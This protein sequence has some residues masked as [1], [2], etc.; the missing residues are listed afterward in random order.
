[1]SVY[2]DRVVK[3]SDLVA[4]DG[5]IEGQTFIGCHIKGPAVI[6]AIES[7]MS[8]C[9]LGGPDGNSVF[10]EVDPGQRPQI[11]G[12][13]VCKRCNFE[14]CTFQAVGFAGPPELRE[15]FLAA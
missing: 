3:L 4:D 2:E 1:M 8:N 11:V 10:W 6:W 14:R 12:A 9:N 15:V 7:T 5:A 13:I